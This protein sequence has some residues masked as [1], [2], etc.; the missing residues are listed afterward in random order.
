MSFLGEV[1]SRIESTYEDVGPPEDAETH[2]TEYT[3]IGYGKRET[4][5]SDYEITEPMVSD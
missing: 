3:E 1:G 2:S 5:T 4:I